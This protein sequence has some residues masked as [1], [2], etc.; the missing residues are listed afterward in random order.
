M[1]TLR[2]LQEHGYLTVFFGLLLEYLGLPIP[3]ELILLFFGA[4]IYWGKLELWVGLVTGLAAVLLGGAR[5][6]NLFP[7]TTNRMFG[8]KFRSSRRLS[9]WLNPTR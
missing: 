3:G 7:K 5:C 1:N 8:M 9:I 6:L 4:L 2:F